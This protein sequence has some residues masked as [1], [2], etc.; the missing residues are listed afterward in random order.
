[1]TPDHTRKPH[2]ARGEIDCAIYAQSSDQ[3]AE[4][5]HFGCQ[6][7]F[8]IHGWCSYTLF[9]IHGSLSCLMRRP[10]LGDGGLDV[11]GVAGGQLIACGFWAMDD[12]W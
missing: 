2:A 11:V 12:A 5:Q 4:V 10:F 7:Y 9:H 1:M 6:K 3:F 8:H